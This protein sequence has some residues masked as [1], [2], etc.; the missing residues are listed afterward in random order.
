MSALQEW[1][2]CFP[3][4]CGTPELKP[5]WGFLLRM[6]DPQAGQPAVGLRTLALAG[7]CLISLFSSLWV[8][9][10]AGTG[11]DYIVKVSPASVFLRLLLCL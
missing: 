7:E 1:S 11:F 3:Q 10:L 4:P 9:H 2:L 6:P 8:A 5:H